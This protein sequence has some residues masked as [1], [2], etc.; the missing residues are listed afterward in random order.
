MVAVGETVPVLEAVAD[1]ESEGSMEADAAADGDTL[2]LVVAVDEREA[3]VVAE[4]FALR[5]GSMVAVGRLVT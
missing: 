4:N 1:G 3:L 2:L 5:V